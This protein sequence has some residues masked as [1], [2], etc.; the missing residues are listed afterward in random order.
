MSIEV[1]EC[2]RRRAMRL[3]ELLVAMA[4]GTLLGFPL[5]VWCLSKSSSTV[6]QLRQRSSNF[7]CIPYRQ[8]QL[9]WCTSGAKV[10][11][12]R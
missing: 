5:G 2:S 6:N 7:R 12:R 4:L 11:V 3:P 8:A 9:N 1:W 10:L